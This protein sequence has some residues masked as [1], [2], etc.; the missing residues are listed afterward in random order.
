ME[1]L[2]QTFQLAEVDQVL[3]KVELHVMCRMNNAAD[4][5]KFILDPLKCL[6]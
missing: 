3:L 4:V 2:Q 6:L 1:N 5:L